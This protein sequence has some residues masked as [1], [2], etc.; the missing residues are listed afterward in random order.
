[1]I[2]S[3]KQNGPWIYVYDEHGNQTCMIAAGENVSFTS[4]TIS[5]QRGGGFTYIY[6]EEGHEIG[7]V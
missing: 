3:I 6:D 4:T 7:M 2:A 5:V 1:M